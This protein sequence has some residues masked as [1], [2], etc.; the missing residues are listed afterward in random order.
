MLSG[1]CV[2]FDCSTMLTTVWFIHRC[3][4]NV[5]QTPASGHK[6][7]VFQACLQQL[8]TAALAGVC[9]NTSVR[10]VVK[11][12]GVSLTCNDISEHTLANVPSSVPS[13]HIVRLANILWFTIWRVDIRSFC[14]DNIQFYWRT[15]FAFIDLCS[16][17]QA[18]KLS[19]VY[20]KRKNLSPKKKLKHPSIFPLE[21]FWLEIT[22]A[23]SS[24][25]SHSDSTS[26]PLP[27][28]Q[29][30]IPGSSLVPATTRVLRPPARKPC[31][32]C[33][34]L[35]LGKTDLQRHIRTHTGERPFKCHLCPY[36]ATVKSTLQS[37]ILSK[38]NSLDLK[39]H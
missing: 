1:E 30:D 28:L 13:V 31:E 8:L 3:L 23:F 35:F 6:T 22:F 32:I 21:S 16:K 10:F 7:D 12:S 9:R 36:S 34:R 17:M 27:Q 20:W 24:Q 38:H 4:Q 29:L 37:H 25:M 5:L 26:H 14:N 33:G 2:R 11:I 18:S 15:C 19:R 39:A